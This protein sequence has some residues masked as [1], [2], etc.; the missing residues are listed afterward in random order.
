MLST[1][2]DPA[3]WNTVA[4][5]DSSAAWHRL[6]CVELG[7]ARSVWAFPLLPFSST[8]LSLGLY[9]SDNYVG[10]L[11]CHL[12]A[13]WTEDYTC[14]HEIYLRMSLKICNISLAFCKLSLVE[15]RMP[16]LLAWLQ[17]S[18]F[19]QLIRFAWVHALSREMVCFTDWKCILGLVWMYWSCISRAHVS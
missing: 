16:V 1:A 4:S 10:G 5:Q 12:R 7:S 18:M 6:S 9:S 17:K 3:T 11:G 19:G 15:Q 8:P 2:C 13:L 14:I